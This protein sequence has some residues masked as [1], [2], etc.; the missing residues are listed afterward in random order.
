MLPF[1]TLVQHASIPDRYNLEGH[2]DK[3]S[4]RCPS[5][6]HEWM[7]PDLFGRNCFA[8][9][10]QLPENGLPQSICTTKIQPSLEEGE[11]S[12]NPDFH[13]QSVANAYVPGSVDL[14]VGPV[15]SLAAQV[16]AELK[17]LPPK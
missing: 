15:S 5:G 2:K 11:P 7:L 13:Q 3:Q 6:L 17:H 12:S 4:V 14:T 9:N 16:A 1:H 8:C 10:N